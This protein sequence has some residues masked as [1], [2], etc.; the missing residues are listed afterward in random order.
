MEKKFKAS[1][2]EIEDIFSISSGKRSKFSID[3]ALPSGDVVV[4]V[5]YDGLI[6][7]LEIFNA[8]KFFS[9]IEKEL[10]KVKDASLNVIYSPSYVAISMNLKQEDKIIRNNLIVPYNKKLVLSA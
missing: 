6:I 3:L 10:V 2:D 7:G 1:Y 4:D 5:G 9:V 8:S